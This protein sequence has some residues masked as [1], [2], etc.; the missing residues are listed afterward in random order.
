MMGGTA[1]VT[2][3]RYPVMAKVVLT[4]EGVAIKVSCREVGGEARDANRRTA[5]RQIVRVKG[6]DRV[7]IGWVRSELVW[8]RGEVVHHIG[9]G[10]EDSVIGKRHVGPAVQGDSLLW[11]G[12]ANAEAPAED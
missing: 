11:S 3:R 2:H 7:W 1:L 8:I 9:A 5:G 12:V 6:R 10:Q 4:L